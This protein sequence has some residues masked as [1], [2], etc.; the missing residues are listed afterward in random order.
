MR[1][2]IVRHGLAVDRAEWE[3]PDS[4][5]PLT[6]EG[7]ARA[8]RVLRAVA[9][10]MTGIVEV[11]TSP[12]ARALATA[13]IAA[14]AWKL[15]LHKHAWLGGNGPAAGD[16]VADLPKQD[17]ALVGHEPDLGELIGVLTGGPAIP[18]KK[19]GIAVLD[20]HPVPGGMVLSLLLTPRAV[21]ELR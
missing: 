20:G 2:V 4:L 19:A 7:R 12:W 5:R 8:K 9:P 16:R 10:L 3:G 6:D 14:D 13:E 11:W 17:T 21:L 18:L 1:L 15:P